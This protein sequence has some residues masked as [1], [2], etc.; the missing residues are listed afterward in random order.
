MAEHLVTIKADTVAGL[1]LIIVLL[2]LQVL[3]MWVLAVAVAVFH[4]MVPAVPVAAV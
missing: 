2:A 1:L 4:Q 3:L